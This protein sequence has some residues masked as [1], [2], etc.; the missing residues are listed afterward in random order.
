MVSSQ[1]ILDLLEP[2]S[3]PSPTNTISPP[4]QTLPAGCRLEVTTVQEQVE[5]RQVEKVVCETEFRPTCT[6]RLERECRNVTVPACTVEERM[7]CE[8]GTVAQCGLEARVGDT[9]E[10]E[11]VEVS[12]NGEE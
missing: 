1:P 10:E 7:E 5:E 4:P 11:Q 3:L 6:V 8:Q 2:C 9:G 12:D